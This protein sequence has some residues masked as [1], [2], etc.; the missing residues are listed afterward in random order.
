MWLC[1]RVPSMETFLGIRLQN[2]SWALLGQVTVRQDRFLGLEG[3]LEVGV[4]EGW[5]AGG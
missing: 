1:D 3:W 5:W 4:L 2:E